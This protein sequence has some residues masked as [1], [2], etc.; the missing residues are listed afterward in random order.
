MID[1]AFIEHLSSLITQ[2]DPPTTDLQK[3]LLEIEDLIASD[4]FQ[5]LD[6]GLR[7]RI[8]DFRR[9]I[10][11]RLKT[12][13]GPK[14]IASSTGSPEIEGIPATGARPPSRPRNPLADQQMEEAEKLFYSGRYADAIRLFDRV[15][16]LEPG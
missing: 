10:K 13:N 1:E 12:V 15:I 11:Q 7:G 9:E 14:D 16:Q 5:D 4:E 6:A 3:A 2:A 8:Q